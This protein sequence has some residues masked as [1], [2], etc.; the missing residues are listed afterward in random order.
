M[1]D[2]G[3]TPQQT[4]QD[5]EP[6]VVT[7]SGIV[8]FRQGLGDDRIGVVHAETTELGLVSQKQ[9]NMCY[10]SS[11][12]FLGKLFISPL[13]ETLPR[14]HEAFTFSSRTVLFKL[15]PDSSRMAEVIRM[16]QVFLLSKCAYSYCSSGY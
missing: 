14:N 11:V 13:N 15:S 3:E 9:S 1:R 6:K 16:L 2:T 12:V 5:R 8:F 4:D 10:N 7:K